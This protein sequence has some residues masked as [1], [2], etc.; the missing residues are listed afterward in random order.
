M[1]TRAEAR[2]T[3][4]T[5]RRASTSA[6]SAAATVASG[7]TRSVASSPAAKE[8][9]EP[10]LPVAR[11]ATAPSPIAPKTAAASSGTSDSR[12]QTPARAAAFGGATLSSA[13]PSNATVVTPRLLAPGS[14]PSGRKGPSKMCID[15]RTHLF[16]VKP[17]NGNGFL[18][19]R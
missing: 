17:W 12:R 4:R 3:E 10:G 2:P 7:T 13:L 9:I 5:G 6:T 1:S 16:F 11:D 14:C 18:G 8:T 15:Q 19:F